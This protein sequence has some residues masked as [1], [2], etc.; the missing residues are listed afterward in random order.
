MKVNNIKKRKSLGFKENTNTK[1]PWKKVK[2]SGN[3]LSDDGGAS[4]E[5]LLGLEVLESYKASSI[6]KDKHPKIKRQKIS[7]KPSN[8]EGS[9]ESESEQSQGSKNQRKK[10]KK[11][12]K[13]KRK[14]LLEK[15]HTNHEPGKFVR[16]LSASSSEL[17]I[18]KSDDLKTKIK[19]KIDEHETQNADINHSALTINDLNVSCYFTFF[20]ILSS[21]IFSLIIN[22]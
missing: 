7:R 15:S 8:C 13:N 12:E 14:K 19:S 20:V 21:Q 6:T 16:P 11:L 18:L 3:L 9:D 2:L 5:G 4:L 22:Y 17:V 10:K 1:L